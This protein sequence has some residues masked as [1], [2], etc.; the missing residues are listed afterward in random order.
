MSRNVSQESEAGLPAKVDSQSIKVGS[1][2]HRT[3]SDP[4]LPE[5]GASMYNYNNIASTISTAGKT[6]KPEPKQ[7]NT[8]NHGLGQHRA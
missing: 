8:S 7:I 6:R 2:P 3:F 5:L 1:T 4:Q